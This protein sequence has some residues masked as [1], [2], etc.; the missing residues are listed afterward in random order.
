MQS[1]KE[2]N[3]NKK[4][5]LIGAGTGREQAV[6]GSGPGPGEFFLAF[7]FVEFLFVLCFA[8]FLLVEAKKCNFFLNYSNYMINI[9]LHFYWMLISYDKISNKI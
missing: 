5:S 4:F 1:R 8:V 9:L 6:V 7:L 3:W 2:G